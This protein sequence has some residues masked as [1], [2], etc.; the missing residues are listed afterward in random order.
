MKKYKFIKQDNLKD[1]G[2]SSLEMIIEYYNGYIPIEILREMTKTDKNGTTAY[3]IVNTAKK[4]GFESYGIKCE[5]DNM[6]NITLPAIAYTVIDNSYKHFMVIYEINYQ[7]Q[8]VVIADPAT[9]IKK[10]SFN[11][12]R[13]IYQNVLIILYPKKEILKYPQKKM[14]LNDIKQILKKHQKHILLIFIITLFLT[15]LNILYFILL[16]NIL[17]QK[18]IYLLFIGFVFFKEIINYLKNKIIINF[19]NKISYDLTEKVIFHIIKLPYQYYKTRT[20]G[21]IITRFQD[22]HK[23]EQFISTFFI[24]LFID[25]F[26]IISSAIF[27]LSISKTLFLGSLIIVLFYLINY[28]FFKKTLKKNYEELTDSIDKT[29]SYLYETIN[30]FETVKGLNMEDSFH[31]KNLTKYKKYLNKLLNY[32]RVC[33]MNLLVKDIISSTSL[34][35]ILYI[36][37][38]LIQNGTLTLEELLIYNTLFS[39]YIDPIKDIFDNM[40]SYKEIKL[41]IKRINDLYYLK[42]DKYLNVPVNNIFVNN[43]TYQNLF[44]NLNL[45][46]EKGDKIALIGKSG[47]GKSTLLK[48]IK[49]YYQ[50][51]N[52]LLNNSTIGNSNILYVSQNEKLFTDTIYNNT[53]LGRNISNKEFTK[54][55]NICYLNDIIH[56]DKLGFYELLEENGFNISGGEKQRIIMARTLLSK[57]D[58]ILFD[59]SLSEVDSNLERKILKK[60]FQE[61][62]N[63]TIIYVAHRLDNIDLFNKVFKLEKQKIEILERSK[64][65]V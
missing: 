7:K 41:I 6:N 45:N 44:N 16:K 2:V 50:S 63:K 26:L 38:Y 23:L 56:D 53:L 27:L 9:K 24:S 49:K 35:T 20:T 47:S 28:Y 37:M 51:N 57:A 15:F 61:Y 55:A 59:E 64:S 48:L 43:L 17:N 33:N 52:V 65:Y 21:E 34:V 8:I 11:E 3:D 36:G 5:L 40:F 58:V 31:K 60:M 10:I 14:F 29:N 22:L 12:F 42:E 4:L 19:S 25:C 32:E 39:F 46:I 62:Q 18:I 30:A 13:K 1:C 54:V